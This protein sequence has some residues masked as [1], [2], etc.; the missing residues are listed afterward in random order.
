MDRIDMNSARQMVMSF[1]FAKRVG[2]ETMM[3]GTHA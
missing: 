1:G 2:M 3:D